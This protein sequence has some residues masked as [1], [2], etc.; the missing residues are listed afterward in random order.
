M[1]NDYEKFRSDPSDNSTAMV[2]AILYVVTAFCAGFAGCGLGESLLYGFL[3]PGIIF[4]FTLLFWL[5]RQLINAF[6]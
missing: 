6:R 3:I 4:A 1:N 5:L 2:M